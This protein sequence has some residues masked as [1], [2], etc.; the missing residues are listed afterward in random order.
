MASKKFESLP[1]TAKELSLLEN[2][3]KVKKQHKSLL[4]VVG[5]KR[6]LHES[7][8]ELLEHKL[9]IA[10]I[11]LSYRDLKQLA[12]GKTVAVSLPLFTVGV[13]KEEAK[14]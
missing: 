3:E 10:N 7:S 6:K 4:A 1:L 14:R 8:Q 11:P 13:Y 2:G 12:K 9:S 5:R